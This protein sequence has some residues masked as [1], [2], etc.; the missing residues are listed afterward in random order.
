MFECYTL[1][2]IRVLEEKAK[3][4]WTFESLVYK[5]VL[6]FSWKAHLVSLVTGFSHCIVIMAQMT[7][8]SNG[9]LGSV[10][11]FVCVWGVLVH[12][13]GVCNVCSRG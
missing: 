11:V 8:M 10:C 3:G 5:T 2:N 9:P 7:L 1:L 6:V 12:V 13:N 4:Q